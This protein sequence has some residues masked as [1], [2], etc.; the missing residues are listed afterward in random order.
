[1]V[2]LKSEFSN[3]IFNTLEDW[4]VILKGT[5]LDEPPEPN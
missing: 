1:M 3:S 2:E 4:E 5:S